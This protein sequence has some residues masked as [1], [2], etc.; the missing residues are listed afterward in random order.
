[1]KY[2]IRRSNWHRGKGGPGSSLL[3]VD[4]MQCCLGFVCEQTG[5][6]R[7]DLLRVP[8]PSSLKAIG[9]LPRDLDFLVRGKDFLNSALSHNAMI[10]ND[11]IV[12][13]DVTRENRLTALFKPH[14]IELEF[15][16]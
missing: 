10:L 14:G 5:V 8:T 16:D 4:G 3:G 2:T 13:D 15:V 11:R 9:K 7:K 12:T 1:M 6:S